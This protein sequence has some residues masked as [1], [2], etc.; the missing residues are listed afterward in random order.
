[1]LHPILSCPQ[2]GYLRSPPS[3]STLQAWPQTGSISGSVPR[4]FGVII[5]GLSR[6]Y[7]QGDSRSCPLQTPRLLPGVY[8]ILG[9]SK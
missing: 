9:S 4:L 1:L 6:F 3:S 8:A 7:R 2:S 5:C